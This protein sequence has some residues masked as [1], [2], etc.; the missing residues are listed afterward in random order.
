MRR[1]LP[2]GSFSWSPR[3][4]RCRASP[5]LPICATA[6]VVDLT[7]PFDQRHALLA[8]LA[9]RLRAEDAGRRP[10][11][12]RLVLLART[13]SALRST[14]ARISTRRATSR[15]AGARPTRFP[16]GSSSRPA[17]VLDVRA[18]GR[19]GSR[20]PPDARRRD[21]PGR[22]RTARSRRARSCSCAPAGARAGRPEGLPGGR[23]A[24][25]RLEAP[26]PFV[27][28]G[29]RG[30][31]R[32]GAEGRAPSASTP[33][34]STT[35]PSKDFVVHGSPTA[36]TSSGLENVAN[37]DALPEQGAWVV[38]LPMKIAGGSGGPLR[39]VALLPLP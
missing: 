38:A 32:R 1:L 23:H 9:V 10:D 3:A 19:E 36:P 31:S 29:G 15:R 33:P 4:F 24:G 7:H 12:R 35:A 39:I 30:V 26:L 2:V 11:A 13:L 27:R 6:K 22:R 21:R 17:V 18:Q 16:C 5:P 28:R 37:L 14:A 34:R 20:L 8:D 25:R